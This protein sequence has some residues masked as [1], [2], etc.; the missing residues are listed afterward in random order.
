[1]NPDIVIA[2]F[3]F[4]VFPAFLVAAEIGRRLG[5][6]QL[7]RD[8]D[9]LPKGTGAAEGSAYAMIGLILAFSFSGAE[10]RFE[11]RRHLIM[12]ETNSIGTAY[13]QLDLLP[14]PA[15][16]SV[17]KDF[18]EYLDTRIA[19]YRDTHDPV[20]I[21]ANLKKTAALQASIW[22]QSLAST[23]L[24]GA[25]PN[26]SVLLLPALNEMFDIATTRKLA[27]NN[28]PPMAIFILLLG[29]NLVGAL[30]SGYATSVNKTRPWF[31]LCILAAVLALTEY[32]IVDL[33]FPRVGLIRVDAA[34]QAL[35]ELRQSIGQP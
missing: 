20:M 28:H 6:A 25:H 2:F 31:Y 17:R 18:L 16:E 1:M 34:D 22:Q 26:A 10:T 27:L 11:A 15:R 7:A 8:P 24:H 33:E 30:L 21:D 3:A 12:S 13:L 32:V 23:M 4:C 14:Q 29:M 5:L 35:V 19:T 9:G